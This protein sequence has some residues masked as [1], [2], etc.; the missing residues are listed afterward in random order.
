[1]KTKIYTTSL[2]SLALA[3][4][5]CASSDKKLDEKLSQETTV[6]NQTQLH[7]EA[8]DLI[9][10]SKGLSA[11]QKTQLMTLRDS[12]RKEMAKV[13]ND[14]VKLRAVLIKDVMAQN[15]NPDEVAD[16]KD[17]MRKTEEKRLALT[18]N[19]VD[20]ANDIIGRSPIDDRDMFFDNMFAVPD[21]HY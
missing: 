9:Q 15:Y 11:E 12:V 6:T 2:M 19:A 14:S 21:R 20:R 5:A 4:A 10:K 7:S 17:R 16:I 3:L 13:Q 8:G 18:F 1:M